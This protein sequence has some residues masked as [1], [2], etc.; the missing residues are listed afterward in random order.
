MKKKLSESIEDYLEVIYRIESKKG[1]VRTSD[2]SSFFG[3]KAS[4]VTEMFQKLDERGLV[5]YEK[6]KGVTLTGKGKKIAKDVSRRHET[7]S[8]FLKILG[9]DEEIAEEDAC[10]IEHAVHKETM[11]TLKDFVSFVQKAPKDPK[12]LRHFRHFIKTG[13]HPKP[14]E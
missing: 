5:N 11:E 13:K 6:Y 10:K 3:H 7:L 8:S 12:W 2:V 1:L 9:V 4:S 14:E